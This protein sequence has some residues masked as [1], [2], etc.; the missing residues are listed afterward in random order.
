MKTLKQIKREMKKYYNWPVE[1]LNR[2][3]KLEYKQQFKKE[4]IK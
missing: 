4:K 3:A 1:R 2:E